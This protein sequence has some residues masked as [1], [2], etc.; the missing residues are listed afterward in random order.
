VFREF[1]VES[2]TAMEAGESW[3]DTTRAF[4]ALMMIALIIFKK[5]R[6]QN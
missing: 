1:H 4:I 3:P 6:A 2:L 5:E